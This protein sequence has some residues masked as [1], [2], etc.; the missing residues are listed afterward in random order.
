MALAR[1]GSA[2][3]ADSYTWPGFVD[4]LATL[5]MV[6]IFVVLVFVLIQVNLAYRVAGQDATLNDMRAQIADLGA[7]L[8]IE[9]KQSADLSAELDRITSQLLSAEQQDEAR[10]ILRDID[11]IENHTAF[12]FD[13][14]LLNRAF[15]AGQG[16][17]TS[18]LGVHPQLE[19]FHAGFREKRGHIARN[20]ASCF[21]LLF[22]RAVYTCASFHCCIGIMVLPLKT[23]VTC[24][25]K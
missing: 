6:I 24:D 16:S 9:R 22:E 1:L 3:R 5:L 12:L 4:A 7:L 14:V 13:N 2:R 23:V 17:L 19:V 21:C 20:N 11:S 15:R 10:Q 25:L 18:N 8:N